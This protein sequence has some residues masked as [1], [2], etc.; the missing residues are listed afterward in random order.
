MLFK[1]AKR[2]EN[3]PPYLFAR[4]EQLIDQ[5]R[6]E[7]VDVISLGIGDP[8]LPTPGHI[9]AEAQRRVADPANHQYPSS[10]GLRAYR[11]AVAAWYEDRFGV[12]LDPATEVVS[13]IGSKEGIAH[14]PWCYL[15]PG[16][17]ALIPDPGYPVYNQ[18]TIL[19]GGEPYY[20]PLHP[21]DGFLPDLA[22]IPP[23]AARRARIMFLNYPNNPTG[24]V[25]NLDFFTSVVDFARRYEIL[26]AHDL[27][28]SE[29]YYDNERPPSLL[30]VPGAKDVTIEFGSVSKP[31]NMTGW[32]IGWAAGNA[33]AVGALGRLKT[34][35]DSG[36]FQAVQYAAIAALRGPQEGTA[37]LRGIYQARRD[38]VVGTLNDLGWRLATPGATF[39]IWAPVPAGH[40]S[41]SFAEE[42]L[43]K[44]GVVIT[45][46][47]GYGTRGEGWFRLSLTVPDARLQEAMRRL[48]ERLGPV[49]F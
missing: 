7:G 43:E 47:P 6:R 17:I 1:E 39:Y 34:N 9:V 22:A 11:E 26:V 36:A 23:E 45:P 40:T 12:T 37:D 33:G 25:A 14:L 27:A 46:G 20:V 49:R 15:D 35:L 10:V 19:A 29:I 16:D 41:A 44:T 32:R 42:V 8:D 13:L 24:A 3:L 18:G 2:V 30:Q 48:R 28:Y 38:L 5:K 31:Y 4:I 21:E